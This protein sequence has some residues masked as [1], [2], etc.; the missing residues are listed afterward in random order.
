MKVDHVVNMEGP[1]QHLF[2]LFGQ[3]CEGHVTK[4]EL[5]KVLFIERDLSK[6]IK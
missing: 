3:N 2:T 5:Y 1:K 4:S 6:D